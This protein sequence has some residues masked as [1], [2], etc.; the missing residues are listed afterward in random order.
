MYVSR[1]FL[2]R[3]R[4][5]KLQYWSF[6]RNWVF[7]WCWWRWQSS[8]TPPWFTLLRENC[9]WEVTWGWSIID[10]HACDCDQGPVGDDIYNEDGAC[11][12]VHVLIRHCLIKNLS[13]GK[14][15]VDWSKWTWID[16][17][18]STKWWWWIT[19][20]DVGDGFDPG[21]GWDQLHWLGWWLLFWQVEFQWWF[22]LKEEKKW[23]LR[24]WWHRW[25]ESVNHPCY[26]WTFVE[27]FWCD[28]HDY[29]DSW[30]L[31]WCS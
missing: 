11:T 31:W 22:L 29:H 4:K 23:Y 16:F 25:R 15:D 30:W 12:T 10:H 14:D 17:H 20:G 8:P 5:I 1:W 19:T 2:M 13:A 7:C 18:F 28:V 9:R 3:N 26:R 24:W 21:P 27:A 6:S